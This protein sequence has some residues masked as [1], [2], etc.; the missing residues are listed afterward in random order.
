MTIASAVPDAG[1]LAWR[2]LPAPARTYVSAVI[3]VGLATLAICIPR[4]AP[5]W[6]LFLFALAAACITSAWK[7]NLPIPLSSG[8]TLSVSYAADL[9]ALL[10]LGPRPAVV[11]AAIGVWTQCTIN[12]KQPYPLYRTVFSVAAEASTMAV[13]GLVFQMLGGSVTGSVA[14][15][16]KP[17]V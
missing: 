11:I 16:A 2:R 3:L 15:L 9:M 12:I 17:V 7:V 8:S 10:L 13:T 4:T 1:G 6:G 14:P 5:P